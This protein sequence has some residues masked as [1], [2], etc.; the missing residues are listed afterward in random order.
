MVISATTRRF[1][2]I[3]INRS[4]LHVG[5]LAPTVTEAELYDLFAQAG[6]IEA[7]SLVIDARTGRSRGF[8]FV[9][10][11]TAEG[12]AA[13]IKQFNGYLFHSRM[14]MVYSVPPRSTK[15]GESRAQI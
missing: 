5:D 14:L 10:M 13:A 11:R 1:E 9:E 3:M 7:L 15:R 8:A 12:A 4:R 6:E 2:N